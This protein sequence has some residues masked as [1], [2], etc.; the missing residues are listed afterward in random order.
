ML[1]GYVRKGDYARLYEINPKCR[2]HR[3][4]VTSRFCRPARKAGDVDVLLGDARLT[5]ERQ[6]PQGVRSAGHRCILERRHPDASADARSVRAVLQAPEAGRR[7]GRAHLESIHRSAC[8]CARDPPQ[9][10][11]RSARVVRSLSDGTYDTSIWV[12]V[13]SN[14]ALLARPEFQRA[15][16]YEAR[17]APSHSRDGRINTAASGR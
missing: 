13:T 1:S 12:M 8:R 3:R 9:Y 11:N 17:A 4:L 6:A 15:N 10:V 7:A 16:T 14:Q 5:L 2:R